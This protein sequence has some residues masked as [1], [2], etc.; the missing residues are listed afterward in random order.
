MPRP[1]IV[2]RSLLQTC[3][4]DTVVH[5][6]SGCSLP[7]LHAEYSTNDVAMS[8]IWT[9]TTSEKRSPP[10]KVDPMTGFVLYHKRTADNAVIGTIDPK[11]HKMSA[12]LNNHSKVRQCLHSGTGEQ[13]E[14]G[15]NWGVKTTQ[16]PLNQLI[17]EMRGR[18]SGSLPGPAHEGRRSH[19]YAAIESLRLMLA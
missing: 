13:L 14:N 8:C 15:K 4:R 5:P 6:V 18:A 1:D 16:N 19:P 17:L 12:S 2:Y 3:D 9:N 11:V 10:D 7:H